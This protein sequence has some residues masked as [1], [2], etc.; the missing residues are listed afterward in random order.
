VF[1]VDI[2]LL[3][4]LRTTGK[5]SAGVVARQIF[6]VMGRDAYAPVVNEGFVDGLNTSPQQKSAERGAAILVHK[7]GDEVWKFRKQCFRVSS[8]AP[9]NKLVSFTEK[10]NT[11]VLELI[12]VE[13]LICYDPGRIYVQVA[14]LY[15]Y[16]LE[17]V[18]SPPLK[19]HRSTMRKRDIISTRVYE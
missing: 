5:K 19:D 10:G 13:V 15:Q 16:I 7:T 6:F 1:S 9:D 18:R 17:S 2:L 3:K 12:Y 4:V 14:R 11:R 8:G